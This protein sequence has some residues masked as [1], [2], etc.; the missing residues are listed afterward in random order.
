MDQIDKFLRVRFLRK[1]SCGLKEKSSRNLGGS[2]CPQ[3]DGKR[4]A[5]GADLRWQSRIS[6]ALRT[7]HSTKGIL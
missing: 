7:T 2:S 6:N 1:E 3:D 5:K 4:V